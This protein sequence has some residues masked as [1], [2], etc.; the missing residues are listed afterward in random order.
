MTETKQ[1]ETKLVAEP[2]RVKMIARRDVSIKMNG[3]SKIVKPGFEFECTEEEAEELEKEFDGYL[4]GTGHVH[5]FQMK[6]THEKIV[7]AE[8]VATGK[9]AS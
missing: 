9:R 3:E 5:D 6:I 1:P 8:R 2:K 4:G 7:R